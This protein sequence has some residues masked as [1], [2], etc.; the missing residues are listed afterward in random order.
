[1]IA[2]Y[3]IGGCRDQMDALA[4]HATGAQGVLLAIAAINLLT[5]LVTWTTQRKRR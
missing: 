2:G 1:M 3:W 5:A 4:E